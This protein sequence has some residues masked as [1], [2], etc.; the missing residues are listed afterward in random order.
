IVKAKCYLIF[1]SIERGDRPQS[2]AKLWQG[3]AGSVLTMLL[4]LAASPAQTQSPPPPS[5]KPST[6]PSSTSQPLRIATRFITPDVFKE[7]GK[8][9]GFSADLG[10]SILEQLQRKA[11]LKTYPTVPEILNAIR[12][13]QADVGIAA[14]AITSQ[15]DKDFDFSYPILSGGLQIMVLAPAEQTQPVE[16]QVLERLSDPNLRRLFYLVALVMLIPA[17]ILW[18]YERHNKEGLIDNPSYVPGIFQA[19]WWTILALLGQAEAMPKGPV[20]KIVGLFWVVVGIVFVAYFT[21]DITAEL[22]VQELQGNIHGLNDLQ[23]RRVAVIA[24]S[25]AIDYL[26]ARNIQ[27]VVEFPQVDQA[28]Q[29]LLAGEV[30]AFVAPGPLLLYYASHKSQG[31]VQ[32]VGTPFLSRFYAIV[33]PKDSPYRRPINQAILT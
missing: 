9:V 8:I 6:S 33:M 31:K 2:Y 18:Y 21:A 4:F 14:I 3:I 16:Q 5:P 25:E 12:S 7:N 32:I 29:A 17:H 13:G 11:V 1:C 27:Q 28:Y 30:D 23:N 26:K 24:D 10:R 22:T 20:G 19:F 15:R